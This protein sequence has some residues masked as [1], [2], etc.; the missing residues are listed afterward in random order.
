MD[1]PFHARVA[2]GFAEIAAGAP[3]RCRV[4]DADGGIEAVHAAIMAVVR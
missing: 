1:A 3:E 2:S 4:V